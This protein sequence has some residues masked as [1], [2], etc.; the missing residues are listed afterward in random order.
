MA[1]LT[2][3]FLQ[4]SDDAGK[5]IPKGKLYFYDSGTTNL[6]NTYIDSGLSIANSNPLILDGAGRVNAP[7]LDGNYRVI[8]TDKDDN[9]IREV[10]PVQGSLS[11]SQWS[12]WSI[13]TTYGA[14]DIVRASNG[15]YY[16]SLTGSNLGNDP[17]SS[18]ANWSQISF[19]TA[20]NINETYS[21]NDNVFESGTQYKSLVDGNIGNLPSTSPAQWGVPTGGVVAGNPVSVL[22]NDVPYLEAGNNLSDVALA[23]TARANLGLGNVDDTSDV[24]KP[25]STLTQA[26]LDTKLPLTGG[27]L[28]GNLNVEGSA[29]PTVDIKPDSAGGFPRCR[30]RDSNDVIRGLFA[31]NENT[32]SL[33]INRFDAAGTVE[34][35]FI[36]TDNGN[37]SVAAAEPTGTNHLT[38]KDYVD[39]KVLNTNWVLK[40]G[41]S[42]SNNVINSW[43]DGHYF[44]KVN[45]D[46]Y[47]PITIK[48]NVIT[49]GGMRST[50]GYILA[51]V[52]Q[53]V[54][55]GA[56]RFQSTYMTVN[57]GAVSTINILEIWK[58]E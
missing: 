1:R 15:E 21:E 20:W 19:V 44:I 35:Q 57:T 29:S 33:Y 48:G 25:I 28:T 41:P 34:T 38:R 50:T 6:R 54:S 4:Y 8:L 24:D 22:V 14:T 31:L 5:P 11:D 46:V 58:A 10:D 3:A 18:P 45:G 27:T 26:A 13:S 36:L 40:W 56:Y 23:A 47:L 51:I 17:I 43:G 12:D 32:G 49:G 39:D 16:I 55:P 30:L 42:S 7:F 37:V 9:Q 53:T 52:Y 2:N